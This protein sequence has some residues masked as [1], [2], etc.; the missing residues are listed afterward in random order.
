MASL[1]PPVEPHDHGL[2]E[3]G[4][5]QH[6]HWEACGSPAGQPALV[7]HGGPGSGCSPWMRRLFDPRRY[8]VVLLDQRG[9]GRSTPR[10]ADPGTSLAVNT[11]HHLLA[12]V[13]ALRTHLGVDRWLVVGISWGSTLATAYAQAH[14]E[15]VTAVVLAA[16]TMTRSVEVE[17]L[18]RGAGRFL[19]VE[20]EAFRDG[21]P[22]GQRSGDLSR[23]YAQL[24]T[25]P[26]ADVRERAARDWCVWEDA[27]AST[28]G[29]GPS[30]RF[31]DPAF[32]Y[33]FARTVTHFFSHAAWLGRDQLLDGA[34]RLGGVPAVLVHGRLD[35]GGPLR[36]AVQLHRA[37]PGSELVVAGR[38]GHLT[39]EVAEHV[40]TATDRFAG[41][42]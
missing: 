15:R 13:E 14:P 38:P 27:L 42:R 35:V 36:T 10:T 33:G 37:W 31:A 39:D 26:D 4:D 25:S 5:G 28:S 22:P 11:T 6:L 16:V 20:W 30:P 1:H 21:V 23:A 12:D 7:L 17:W 8:R 29:S 3:V 2:L 18:T 24:L 34:A 40:T 32:R 9:A 41:A 19:P